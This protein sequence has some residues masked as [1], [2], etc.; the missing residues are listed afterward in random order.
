MGIK[1]D[2]GLLVDELLCIFFIIKRLKLANNALNIYFSHLNAN[3][4][5]LHSIYRPQTQ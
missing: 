4:M 3:S 5:R 1:S 2:E